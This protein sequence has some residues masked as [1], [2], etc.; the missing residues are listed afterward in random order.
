MAG[1]F[2]LVT[3]HSDLASQGTTQYATFLGIQHNPGVLDVVDLSAITA[4][5][6][7]QFL[8]SDAEF[9]AAIAADKSTYTSPYN[10][11]R[12]YWKRVRQPRLFDAP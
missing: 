11:I 7:V 4:Q 6:L 8:M 12:Q 10:L 1:R 5:T 3:L 9:N 2:L